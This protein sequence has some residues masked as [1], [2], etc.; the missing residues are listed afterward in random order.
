[1]ALTTAA[2]V[3]LPALPE[4]VSAPVVPMAKSSMPVEVL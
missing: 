3:P 1:M 2:L 4:E